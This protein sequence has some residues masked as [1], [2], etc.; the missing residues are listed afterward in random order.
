MK[1]FENRPLC[2]LVDNGSLDPSAILALRRVAR[3]LEVR[4]GM[5]TE[6]V[7]LK[8]SDKAEIAELEDAPG[9][10]VDTSLQ[11]RLA[12]GSRDFLFL[13]FFLGPSQGIT[14]WL[15]RKLEELREQFPDLRAKVAGSL[16]GK[17]EGDECLARA[18]SERVREIIADEGLCRPVVALVDHGTP[19]PEVNRARER[20]GERVRE[21]PGEDVAGLRTCSMERRP[22]PDYAF[23]EPLL[24]TLLRDESAVP[25]G[26]V[27]VAQF[28]L[29]PGRHAGK[30]GDVSEICREAEEVRPRLRLH[31]TE[32]LGEHPL[33]LDLLE[34]RLRESLDAG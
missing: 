15:P 30:G 26:D 9:E 25:S 17:G 34:Q 32:P 20:V 18:V 13:P 21:L 24:A 3:R 11:G 19:V 33:L 16:A 5:E 1:T 6:A 4:T 29:S 2:L 7:G 14:D 28:F 23:N 27:V 12:A 10:T 31:L 22:E 8:H